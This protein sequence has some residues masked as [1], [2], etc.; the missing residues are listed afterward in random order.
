MTTKLRWL[1]SALSRFLGQNKLITYHR[2][3]NSPKPK[4]D[5][6]GEN[7]KVVSAQ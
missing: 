1:P 2:G 5:A 6:T 4:I 7:N 3:L